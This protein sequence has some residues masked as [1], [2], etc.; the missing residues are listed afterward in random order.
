[1]NET[2]T[3]GTGGTA[4]RGAGDRKGHLSMNMPALRMLLTGLAAGDALGASSEFVPRTRVPD[5][6]RR[7]AAQGW[8]FR[9]VGGDGRQPGQTTDDTEMALCIVRSFL[10][11]GGFEGADVARRFVAWLE[12]EPR[13]IGR[14][15]RQ[16]LERIAAGVPWHEGGLAYYRRNPDHAANGSLMRNG[17][18]A[19][20]TPSLREAFRLTVHHGVT[21]HYAPLPMLCCATQTWMLCLILHGYNPLLE[22]GPHGLTTFFFSAWRDW[23][24]KEQDEI[25]RLWRGCTADHYERACWALEDACFDPESFDPFT[26][27]IGARAGYCLLTLQIAVWAACWS[28]R[29]EPFPIPPGLPAEVFQRRGPYVLGWVAMIGEDADTYGATAGPLIAAIHGGLPAELS[30]GLW[31]LNEPLFQPSVGP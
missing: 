10:E 4:G 18:S 15:T 27:E 3:R 5:L 17:V 19:A 21:T 13:D 8:P 31:I 11:R 25:V 23:L 7:Y 1:M 16:A 12:G 30:E 14:T 6:Y 22:V 20:L 28:M 2:T 29:E 9:P 26:V 24:E